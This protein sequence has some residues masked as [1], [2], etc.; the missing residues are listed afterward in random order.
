MEVRTKTVSTEVRVA[1]ERAIKRAEEKSFRFVT[2][3]ELDP[4]SKADMA[5]KKLCQ[6]QILSREELDRPITI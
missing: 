1:L 5:I 2:T 6:D 3:G 4:S